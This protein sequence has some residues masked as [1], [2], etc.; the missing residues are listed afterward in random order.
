M[1]IGVGEVGEDLD[2]VWVGGEDVA[3]GAWVV[4]EVGRCDDG[5][6][7]RAEGDGELGVMADDAELKGDGGLAEGGGKVLGLDGGARRR[8]RRI[9]E[10]DAERFVGAGAIGGDEEVRG[11]D[12]GETGDDDETVGGRGDEAGFDRVL[13][14]NV[15][16]SAS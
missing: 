14:I 1:E 2:E 9:A 12:G 6:W 15:A 11:F 3:L 4:V 5:P 10:D 8:K 16:K 7:A 13:E